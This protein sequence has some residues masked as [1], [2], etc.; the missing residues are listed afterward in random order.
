[1]SGKSVSTRLPPR[2]ASVLG[3]ISLI[4]GVLSSDYLGTGTVGA[5]IGTFILMLVLALLYERFSAS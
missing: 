2:V 1:M 4:I 3:G 5:V